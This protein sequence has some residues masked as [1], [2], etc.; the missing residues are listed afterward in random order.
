[1]SEEIEHAAKMLRKTT[2]SRAH[3]KLDWDNASESMREWYRGLAR[4]MI[5]GAKNG[6]SD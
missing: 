1:M 5:E 4:R 2:R 6:V 3:L